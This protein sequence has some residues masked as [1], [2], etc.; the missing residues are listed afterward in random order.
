MKQLARLDD[1]TGVASDGPEHRWVVT[2]NLLYKL[3]KCET[4][5]NN[6]VRNIYDKM[7][8]YLDKLNNESVKIIVIF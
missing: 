7:K 2:G 6:N 8:T 3:H 5:L 4:H 1:T